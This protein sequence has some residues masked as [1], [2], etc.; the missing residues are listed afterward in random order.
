ME[1]PTVR[2]LSES[3]AAV[4]MT[5]SGVTIMATVAAGTRTPP[6]PKA[7]R[8]PRATVSLGL[9]GVEADREPPKA[10]MKNNA[11]RR[12][13]RLRPGKVDSAALNPIAPR[14][15]VKAGGRPFRPI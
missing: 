9:F 15:V 3:A 4:V 10:V 6:T 1:P 5:A 7:A 14:V 8:D 11:T 12:I 2:M 13:S